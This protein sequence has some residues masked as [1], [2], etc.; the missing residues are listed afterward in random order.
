MDKWTKPHPYLAVSYL[1]RLKYWK[2]YDLNVISMC[3][4]LNFAFTCYSVNWHNNRH[5]SRGLGSVW[6]LYT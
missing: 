4:S 3:R 1:E 6:F 5:N 2:A